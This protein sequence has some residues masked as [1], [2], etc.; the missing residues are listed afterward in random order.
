MSLPNC[1][2]HVAQFSW[3]GIGKKGEKEREGSEEK[4]EGDME[5]DGGKKGRKPESNI[6]PI[7]QPIWVWC[8]LRRPR[9]TWRRARWANNVTCSICTNRTFPR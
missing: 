1:F 6:M 8:G 7:S 4:R 2:R 3:A 5:G 9:D